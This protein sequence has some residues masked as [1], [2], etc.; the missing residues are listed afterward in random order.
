MGTYKKKTTVERPKHH[1]PYC[2]KMT[3][4]LYCRNCQIEGWSEVHKM[5]G[6]TNGWDKKKVEKV[7]GG[8]RSGRRKKVNGWWEC[9]VWMTGKADVRSVSWR[10][11]QVTGMKTSIGKRLD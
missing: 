9:G 2:G 7:D 10:G 4:S 3:E 5:F 1:C 8:G 11:R 6:S